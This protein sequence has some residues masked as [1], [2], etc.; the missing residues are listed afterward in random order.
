MYKKILIFST[1]ITSVFMIPIFSSIPFDNKI[2]LARDVKA[3]NKQNYIPYLS[4]LNRDTSDLDIDNMTLENAMGIGY[5][6]LY[7]S[8]LGEGKELTLLNV[9]TGIDNNSQELGLITFINEASITIKDYLKNNFNAIEIFRYKE[10]GTIRFKL[11][12][13]KGKIVRFA[14]LKPSS[15]GNGLIYDKPTFVDDYLE[16]ALTNINSSKEI[17]TQDSVIN[18]ANTPLGKLHG[19]KV[20]INDIIESLFQFS[21]SHIINDPLLITNFDKRN[22]FNMYEVLFDE[23]LVSNGE[24]KISGY[25]YLKRKQKTRFFNN[26]TDMKFKFTL[27]G[28]N[29]IYLVKQITNKLNVSSRKELKNI[30]ASK[31]DAYKPQF[32]KWFINY[33]EAPVIK[34]VLA[35]TNLNVNDFNNILKPKLI[36]GEGSDINDVEGTIINNK[37]IV[38]IPIG[39]NGSITE[40]K[41]L[42]FDLFGFKKDILIHANKNK[43]I[44]IDSKSSLS[45]F[46]IAE[47][48]KDFIL[49]NLISFEQTIP[50]NIDGSSVLFSTN[51]SYDTFVS[52]AIKEYSIFSTN[53]IQGSLVFK[54]TLN[55]SIDV[56]DNSKKEF[57]FNIQ[58]FKSN[59]T[60]LNQ[61][62]YLD[63]KNQQDLQN[64]EFIKKL[65]INNVAGTNAWVSANAWVSDNQDPIIDQLFMFKDDLTS[66]NELFAINCT[67]DF[68]RTKIFDSFIL[69]YKNQLGIIK[70]QIKIKS[71][72]KGLFQN[73]L[74]INDLSFNV[75]GYEK[76]FKTTLDNKIYYQKNE[77]P[78]LQTIDNIDQ[79]NIFKSLI[80]FNSAVKNNNYLL[81]TS[82][83]DIDFKQYFLKSISINKEKDLG[84]V[85]VNIQLVPG[86]ID[87][88]INIH[89]VI[90]GYD[91]LTPPNEL[92]V[93]NIDEITKIPKFKD[94]T[95]SM[96]T[97]NDVLD[98]ISYSGLNQKYSILDLNCARAT[99]EQ[100]ILND[101]NI[102]KTYSSAKVMLTLKNSDGS[103][104]QYISMI[105]GFNSDLNIGLIVGLPIA[106]IVIIAIGIGI[107]IYLN[108]RN[109]IIKEMGE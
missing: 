18:I 102:E 26:I 74:E 92:K 32:L 38:N 82:I 44:N 97:N 96:F 55:D 23:K 30:I 22:F 4:L 108:K 20:L 109:K 53:S 11:K 21:D 60:I 62:N 8:E 58:G 88:V 107:T 49:K 40:E 81:T 75:I 3:I 76:E 47:I 9:K 6:N 43:V 24:T 87:G 14:N 94:M 39:S 100:L 51:I 35:E 27:E 56:I 29:G 19:S 33:S 64:F 59:V 68:F 90:C 54:I 7:Q 16:F 17:V 70:M 42:Y 65:D 98:L 61:R 79:D 73:G 86:F 83:S 84:L 93:K 28:F 72:F 85:N 89:F 69:E 52:N 37:L 36:F 45:N 67:R 105:N 71:T 34:N 12:V 106:I 50:S 91:I 41:I 31:F 63:I 77:Y 80:M 10:I 15:T 101:I 66:S 57:T 1:F 13:I 103:L 46:N 48:D 2:E 25:I 5:T 78:L 95:P 99:F 104:S